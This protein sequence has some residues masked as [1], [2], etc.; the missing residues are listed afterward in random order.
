M[1]GFSLPSRQNIVWHGRILSRK[2][3]ETS[4][5]AVL[6]VMPN[7]F[8]HYKKAHCVT[9]VTPVTLKTKPH[10]LQRRKENEEQRRRCKRKQT[11]IL[12]YINIYIIYL[13]I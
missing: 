8:L 7:Q 6:K 9:P 1:G 3:V 5:R 13:N 12:T 4:L 11:I 2:L 10:Y